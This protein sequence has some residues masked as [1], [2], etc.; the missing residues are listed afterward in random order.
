MKVAKLILA[1]FL[2]VRVADGQSPSPTLR[3][4]PSSRIDPTTE[5]LSVVSGVAVSLRGDIAL[6]QAQDGNV[7]IYSSEGQR[8]GR[9]G[10]KGS[11]PG[12]F[13]ALIVARLGWFVDTLWVHDPQLSRVA[14]FGRDGRFLRSVT[15]PRTLTWLNQSIA[16]GR[17]I[18]IDFTAR[19]AKPGGSFLGVVTLR[20]NSSSGGV[21][22]RRIVA[23]VDSQWRIVRIHLDVPA[24]E[25]LATIRNGRSSFSTSVPYLGSVFAIADVSGVH[26][27]VVSDGIGGGKVRT[28]RI[29][30]ADSVRP[31]FVAISADDIPASTRAEVIRNLLRTHSDRGPQVQAELSRQF[32]ARTPRHYGAVRSATVDADGVVSVATDKNSDSTQITRI[33]TSGVV[34]G[35]TIVPRSWRLLGADTK[36]L[37]F[38]VVDADGLMAMQRHTFVPSRAR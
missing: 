38:G 20:A 19:A 6:V 22:D 25:N 17:G 13:Q 29:H 31:R 16:E 27:L 7:L 36:S 12:E 30:P 33:S 37:W 11:G 1:G 23:T 28:V 34:T 21:P 10:R 3:L 2:L 35:S 14:F 5:D 32:E 8:L 15:V 4:N 26:A 24:N 18:P 9:A